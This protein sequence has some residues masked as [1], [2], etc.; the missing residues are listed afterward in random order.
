MKEVHTVAKMGRPKAESPKK[1][2]VS[3]RMTEAEYKKLA[4][5]AT[6]HNLTITEVLHKGVHLL[7]GTSE[8]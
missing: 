8:C 1:M 3:F 2:N 5:Y 6:E 7:Y 4:E